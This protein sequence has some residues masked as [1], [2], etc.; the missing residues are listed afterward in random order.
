MQ[1]AILINED[2]CVLIDVGNT[3]A[4]V[5]WRIRERLQALIRFRN[6]YVLFESIRSQ[7]YCGRRTIRLYATKTS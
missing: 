2:N 4:S 6:V 5:S 7:Y 1:A 3:R